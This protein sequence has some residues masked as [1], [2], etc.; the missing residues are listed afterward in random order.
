MKTL[1]KARFYRNGYNAMRK[2]IINDLIDVLLANDESLQLDDYQGSLIYNQIDDQESQ[3]IQSIA[4]ARDPDNIKPPKVIVW[5][6]VY[7]DSENN[8]DIEELGT[9]LLLNICDAVEAVINEE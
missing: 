5:V 9:E 6:G 7:G 1:D 4:L 8:V 2:A 3:V